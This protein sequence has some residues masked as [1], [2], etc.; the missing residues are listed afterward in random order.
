MT[1][2]TI[3]I[4]ILTNSITA[5]ALAGG[6][7]VGPELSPSSAEG[8]L[9]TMTSIGDAANPDCH[10]VQTIP[11]SLIDLL[12]GIDERRQCSESDDSPYAETMNDCLFASG[13]LMFQLGGGGTVHTSGNEQAS[14]HESTSLLQF[15][16][17]TPRR[18]RIEWNVGAIGRA[19][20]SAMLRL[21]EQHIV[22]AEAISFGELAKD[23]GTHVMTIQAGNWTLAARSMHDASTNALAS[24]TAKVVFNITALTKGDV[25]GNGRADT[26]DILSVISDWGACDES[27][28][29]ADLDNDGLIGVQDLML[30]LNDMGNP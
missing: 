12:S 16:V 24:G 13:G 6:G 17:P 23:D 14:Q 15:D 10:S 4:S 1:R 22:D 25:D 28:C 19:A 2:T 20:C 11:I 7:F 9:S 18:V 8:S 21:G 26:N 3:S 30:V 5:A 27:S 29:L